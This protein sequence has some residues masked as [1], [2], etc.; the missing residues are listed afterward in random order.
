MRKIAV[1]DIAE[2]LVL[3]EDV[4][5]AGGRVIANRSIVSRFF[6]HITAPVGST[7]VA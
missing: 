7:R 6:G 4:A 3:A 2:G 1:A 5:D